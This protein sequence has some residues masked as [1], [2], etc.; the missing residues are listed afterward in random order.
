MTYYDAAMKQ[1][2]EGRI[3]S[4]PFGPV[5]GP[6]DLLKEVER[7]AE[8]K[9]TF[10]Q[11]LK[12]NDY[13]YSG[14]PCA[15]SSLTSSPKEPQPEDVIE[16]GWNS[17]YQLIYVLFNGQSL[18]VG[19]NYYAART[20]LKLQRINFFIHNAFDVRADSIYGQIAAEKGS[21]EA[22]KTEDSPVKE[23]ESANVSENEK[24][25]IVTEFK[26]DPAKRK[27]WTEWVIAYVYK[28]AF[29]LPSSSREDSKIKEFEFKEGPY[30]EAEMIKIEKDQRANPG[31]D[32]VH[33]ETKKTT[34]ETMDSFVQDA[35]KIAEKLKGLEQTYN[36]ILN[37]IGI[38]P[39]ADAII[40]C[41]MKEMP[42]VEDVMIAIG[43]GD[44][45][46]DTQ[47][48]IQFIGDVL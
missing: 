21:G 8:W 34:F 2:S 27:P 18:K 20:P 35:E 4:F 37:K 36:L 26:D 48:A 29:I 22:T 43:L 12:T 47:K 32:K 46:K 44:V 41:L 31:K 40:N 14:E 11:F 15:D 1:D 38:K 16:F 42:T 25:G 7:L 23:G 17:E 30:S 33:I 3:A 28:D 9:E 45:F 13:D 5:R 19:L 24:I 10:E 39:L 6:L